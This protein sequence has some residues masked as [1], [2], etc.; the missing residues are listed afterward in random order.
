[1]KQFGKILKFELKNYITNKI[2]IGVTIFLVLIIAIVMFIPRV[3]EGVDNAQ[4]TESTVTG[5]EQS[6][7]ESG[8]PV[9]LVVCENAEDAVAV[10][11]AF[12]EAFSEYEVRISEAD[13]DEIE[14]QVVSGKAEC[15]FVMD[16]LIS[17]KYY[18]NNLSMYDTNES[19]ADEVLKNVYQISEMK[20][21]G[22]QDEQAQAVLS[23]QVKHEVVSFGKDTI[24]N[25]FYTYIM[26]F[27][28][29][30]VILLYGQMVATNV[31][32]EKSSRAMELLITSARPVSMMFGKVLSSCIAGFVQLAIVFG[33]SFLFFNFNKSYW[34]D[35]SIMVSIF[36][37]PLSLFIYML[38]FFVFGFL[39]YA[40]LYGAIGSTAS[41]LEDINT[42]VMP[43]TL[44]FIIAFMVVMYSMASDTVDN[45]LMRVCSYIPFTS[46]MAMFTRIAMSTVPFYEVLISII[47]LIASVI[48]TG[49]LA[50]KI[51]RVGVLLYGTPPKPKEILKAVKRMICIALVGSMVCGCLQIC[52]TKEVK[53]GIKIN[54]TNLAY[55]SVSGRL[56]VSG[57]Q[58]TDKNKKPVQLKG[59][60]TH[61]LSWYPDY[62]NNECFKELRNKWGVNCIRLAMYTEEYNG[63]CV[64]GDSNK[65]ELKSLIDK[66]VKC[67]KANDMYVIIDW[68]IL[69]DGNPDKNK[70]EALKFFR[71]MSKKY[72]KYNN[73][74]YEICNEPNGGTD[75]EH[76][77]KYASSVIKTIRKNDK[78]AVIIVGTPTWSQDVDIVSKSPVKGYKNI[79][80]ALHFY[81]ATHTDFLRNKMVTA[82]ENGLPVFV[83]EY[84][85][86]DASGNGAI[87]RVQAGKWLDILNQY[88]VSYIAWNLSNKSETSAIIKNSCSKTS[89]FKK[90]ELTDSGK[91]LYNMLRKSAGAKE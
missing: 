80:Y 62:V 44:L 30:M 66:G 36:D 57:T 72:K 63:Y 87:D 88:K 48:G 86:C 23:V 83:S 68:H 9:M 19:T 56:K 28:L 27:A 14:E 69:S 73:V 37:M 11:T 2:F 81:A 82:I 26:V 55:P 77:K 60:S 42:S 6:A 46:P 18:V 40:F 1:M 53:A 43:V 47:I 31:A 24:K 76:I 34:I 12:S 58:L 54:N 41:R 70:S 32:S 78:K 74:I 90:S 64:G 33:S 91:W 45:V 50:A 52:G 39:I 67:A 10:R 7:D 21:A 4:N 51:Y 35:N 3:L 8:R 38:I 25:Y 89:G 71:Q 59:I 65:R 85:I 75:W 29:Y 17:Y 16:N 84:G 79:M 49:V 5:D 13:T 15:A 20:K 61:G 22:L